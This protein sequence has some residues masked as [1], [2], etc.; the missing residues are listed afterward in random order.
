ME[1]TKSIKIRMPEQSNDYRVVTFG[2]GGVGKS[3]LGEKNHRRCC[4]HPRMRGW[5]VHT[6]TRRNYIIFFISSGFLFW[7]FDWQQTVEWLPH[8][9]ILLPNPCQ[10]NVLFILL[11]RMGRWGSLWL[12]ILGAPPRIYVL[13]TQ[14]FPFAYFL[15]SVL[16]FIKGTFPTNYIPT[17]EDTYRQVGWDFAFFLLSCYNWLAERKSDYARD[18]CNRPQSYL[19][20]NWVSVYLSSRNLIDW[21]TPDTSMGDMLHYWKHKKEHWLSAQKLHIIFASNWLEFDLRRKEINTSGRIPYFYS[22]QN[23]NTS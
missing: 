10:I 18:T 5:G 9:N 6:R 1:S 17:I 12:L 2:S 22:T 19:L 14:S 8:T 13:F 4:A 3:S 16:R 21:P 15:I 7:A 11:M 20:C 23:E